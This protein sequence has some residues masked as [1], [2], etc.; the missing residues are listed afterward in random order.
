MT[1]ET[2][3][4]LL[5]GTGIILVI[6]FVVSDQLSVVQK[7]DTIPTSD[8]S[9]DTAE[10]PNDF[11]SSASGN[12]PGMDF[13]PAGS[14]STFG[15]GTTGG[16]SSP[17]AAP[18]GLKPSISDQ[19][20]P[21]ASLSSS[22]GEPVPAVS[23]TERHSTTTQNDITPLNTS[24]STQSP[25]ASAQDSTTPMGLFDPSP[26][27]SALPNNASSSSLKPAT[28]GISSPVMPTIESSSVSV[29]KT[30]KVE[31]GDTLET[32]S[33]KHLGAGKHW[34]ELLKANSDKIKRPQD[35]KPGMMLTLPEISSTSAMA[36]A[37]A[38]TDKP[39]DT[40]SR[41]YTVK[42]GDSLYSIARKHLGNGER[43]KEILQANSK[44][45]GGSASNLKP[46]MKITLPAQTK[47][48]K[49]EKKAPATDQ[50]LSS[51]L[52]PSFNT[53]STSSSS[54]P[55][56]LDEPAN[57]PVQPVASTTKTVG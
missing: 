10:K 43:W 38:S 1:K 13:A 45:L 24:A 30:I 25:L 39:S 47:P 23:I 7:R 20:L 56:M 9:L 3:V 31:A 22:L 42:S 40:S 8:L 35:L 34:Q 36:T 28:S 18:A 49:S 48:S 46:G 55:T 19:P 2:K 57:A 32:L 14:S 27:P 54:M 41:T 16:N 37:P 26:A 5:I 17:S 50:A 44:L 51:S 15:S 11:S 29:S 33:K 6:G 53:P 52:A 4:G 12:L 21:G